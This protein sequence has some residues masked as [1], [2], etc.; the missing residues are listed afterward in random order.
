MLAVAN[1]LPQFDT[2]RIFQDL[3]GEEYVQQLNKGKKNI[4][5]LLESLLTLQEDIL[6]QN[7]E[8][9]TILEG[10]T[11]K[12]VQITVNNSDEEIPSDMEDDEEKNI[13]QVETFK[14][15]LKKN[16]KRKLQDGEFPVVLE[17]CFKSFVPY[18]Q[19]L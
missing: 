4:K 15:V 10:E 9:I 7:P 11:S 8:T 16:R 3:G 19:V 18:R 1:R 17:K 6:R 2:Y 14:P 5:V 12:A 13:I